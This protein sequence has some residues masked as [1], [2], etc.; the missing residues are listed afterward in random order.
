MM[1][2]YQ[3]IFGIN[4]ENHLYRLRIQRAFVFHFSI[5]YTFEVIHY[6]SRGEHK[7]VEARHS[8]AAE[9]PTACIADLDVSKP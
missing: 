9:G 7:P 3:I 4:L 8:A 6:N 1:S 5:N 2:K